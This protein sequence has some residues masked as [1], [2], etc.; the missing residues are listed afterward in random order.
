MLVGYEA[1]ELIVRNEALEVMSL[2]EAARRLDGDKRWVRIGFWRGGRP[3][4]R[5]SMC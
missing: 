2:R 4:E 1:A 3:K 5:T